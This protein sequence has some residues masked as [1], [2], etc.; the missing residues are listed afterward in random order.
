MRK[1]GSVCGMDQIPSSEFTKAPARHLED[2]FK[3]ATLMITRYGRPYVVISPPSD[4]QVQ[5]ANDQA[6]AAQAG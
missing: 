6:A 2:V 5:A 3:G 1:S 4:E